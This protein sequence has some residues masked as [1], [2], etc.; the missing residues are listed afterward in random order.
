MLIEPS[1]ARVATTLL[2][3][4][5]GRRMPVAFAPLESVT[6]RIVV[7]ASALVR[8]CVESDETRLCRAWNAFE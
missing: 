5:C 7:F 3:R 1:A 6:L 4:S 8:G 2:I